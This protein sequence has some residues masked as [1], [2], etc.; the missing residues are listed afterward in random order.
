MGVSNA[1]MKCQN[2]KSDESRKNITPMCLAVV[3]VHVCACEKGAAHQSS[4]RRHEICLFVHK[5]CPRHSSEWL[6]HTLC[7]HADVVLSHNAKTLSATTETQRTRNR[8]GELMN[9]D[10]IDPHVGTRAR[11]TSCEMCGI[12]NGT[13]HF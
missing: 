1:S 5:T 11:L 4:I 9:L 3:C 7:C 10:A 13:V 6:A 2:R 12:K 8:K